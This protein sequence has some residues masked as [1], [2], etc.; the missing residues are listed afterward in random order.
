LSEKNIEM[1][2]KLINEKKNKNSNKE[3]LRPSRS[4]SPDQRARKAIRSTKK[5]GVFDK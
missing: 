4:L 5:G 2:K 3:T 1:M